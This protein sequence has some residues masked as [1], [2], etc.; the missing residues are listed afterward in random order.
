[1]IPLDS[2]RA[3]EYRTRA[4]DAEQRAAQA[5][6]PDIQAILLRIADTYRRMATQ[7]RCVEAMWV[8]LD[9][10]ADGDVARAGDGHPRSMRHLAGASLP[11][12]RQPERR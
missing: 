4:D 3:E 5:R 1:M 6:D 10:I 9:A 7:A 2:A 12:L 11:P 8:E